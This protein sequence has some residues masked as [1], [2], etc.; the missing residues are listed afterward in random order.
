MV[1][2]IALL[3]ILTECNQ[4]I[5][6]GPGPL[7]SRENDSSDEGTV[8]MIW[9]EGVIT[10][11]PQSLTPAARTV[12]FLMDHQLEPVIRTLQTARFR[13]QEPMF[14]S[15]RG[16]ISADSFGC[17]RLE[18]AI[19]LTEEEGDQMVHQLAVLGDHAESPLGSEYWER[20]GDL[21]PEYDEVV[22]VRVMPA[23]S[24]ASLEV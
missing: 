5:T 11:P 15:M 9:E 14:W 7:N 6:P 17:Y 8:A 3:P 23:N 10:A 1:L 16:S 20:H 13:D 4:E 12:S 21:G 19:D 18:L 2:F 24:L 22:S